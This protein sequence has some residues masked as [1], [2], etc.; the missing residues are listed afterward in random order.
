[1]NRSFIHS[2][3]LAGAALLLSSCY[4]YYRPYGAARYAAA[5]NTTPAPR[6]DKAG[7]VPVAPATTAANASWTPAQ[8]DNNG[9]PI[10][11]YSYGRPVYGYTSGGVAL[12]TFGA[13]NASCY[14]PVWGPAGW[15]RGSWCYPRHVHRVHVPR[16]FPHGHHP[17]IHFRGGHHHHGH[18]RGGHGH[19]RGG[20]R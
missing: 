19:F 11:G 17:G 9:F 18:F 20:R 1:M 12:Y 13:I 7:N 16:H 14:V 6:T 3:I 8:Y 5:A 15:Y 10:Y 4:Y 2:M